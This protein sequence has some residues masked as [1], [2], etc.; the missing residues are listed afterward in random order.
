MI[1]TASQ[2]DTVPLRLVG[3][4]GSWANWMS[5]AE[6]QQA[7]WMPERFPGCMQGNQGRDTEAGALRGIN[8][9]EPFIQ[10]AFSS[11]GRTMYVLPFSMGPVG[12]PLSTLQCSSTQTLPTWW[13]AYGP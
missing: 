9:L 3:P 2:R 8:R 5:P 10:V 13:Q 11:V 6:F 12:S 1:V 7:S 4:V